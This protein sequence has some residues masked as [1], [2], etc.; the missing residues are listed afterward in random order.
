MAVWREL[1]GGVGRGY[2]KSWAEINLI[3][4]TGTM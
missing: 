1:V 4:L 2:N 3:T